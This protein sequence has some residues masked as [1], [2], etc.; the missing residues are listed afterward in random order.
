LYVVQTVWLR[1]FSSKVL[2][3]A[4]ITNINRPE[5]YPG[6]PDEATRDGLAALFAQLFPD[7]PGRAIDP[8]HAGIALAAHNP[9][10]AMKL[11]DLDPFPIRFVFPDRI[12]KGLNI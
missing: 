2:N 5:D 4:R 1:I 8:S 6:N 11:A 12:R 3:M 10:L 7:Q 9:H